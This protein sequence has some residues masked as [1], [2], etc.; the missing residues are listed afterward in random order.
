V[1]LVEGHFDDF[2]V[3]Q[4]LLDVEEVVHELTDV[5]D[6]I[7]QHAHPLAHY[8]VLRGLADSRVH[9]ELSCLEDVLVVLG[10]VE[11]GEGLVIEL[12][13][14]VYLGAHTIIIRQL[15]ERPKEEPIGDS[16]MAW[17]GRAF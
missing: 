13:V 8:D 7:G 17:E 9:E 14:P 3:G 1:Y 6:C 11:E 10:L 2:L 4:L 16:C 5:P 12:D 15:G